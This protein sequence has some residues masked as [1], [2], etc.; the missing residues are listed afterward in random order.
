MDATPKKYVKVLT[1]A[2]LTVCSSDAS[3]SAS[4]LS[5]QL[6][7]IS[8]CSWKLTGSDVSNPS[9]EHIAC[10]PYPEMFALKHKKPAGGFGEKIELPSI[11]IPGHLRVWCTIGAI[12]ITCLGFNYFSGPFCKQF[13]LPTIMYCCTI[14]KPLSLVVSLAKLSTMIDDIFEWRKGSH[15]LSS[16]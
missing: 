13:R 16:M 14:D 11:M 9:L 3:A 4:D 12:L 2:L 10:V 15:F 5:M 1:R 8:S 6:K 7:N